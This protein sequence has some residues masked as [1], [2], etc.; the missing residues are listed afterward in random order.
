MPSQERMS[1]KEDVCLCSCGE[2]WL[3]RDWAG[4]DLKQLIMPSIAC[5]VHKQDATWAR[6][7]PQNLILCKGEGCLWK[8]ARGRIRCPKWRKY[9]WQ[10]S[11][12]KEIP[13]VARSSVLLEDRMQGGVERSPPRSCWACWDQ[14]HI[15]PEAMQNKLRALSSE[16]F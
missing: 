15:V 14:L 16:T 13:G 12:A 11:E 7:R 5:H 9:L 10:V 3:G 4:A 1:I 8:S 2:G 6:T